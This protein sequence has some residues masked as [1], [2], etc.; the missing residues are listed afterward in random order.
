MDLGQ[1]VSG[2]GRVSV[3]M[4]NA[5]EAARQARQSQL[6]TEQLNRL[7]QLRQE[8]LNAPM[9]EQMQVPQYGPMGELPV[10]QA[11]LTLP[12][13]GGLRQPITGGT[14]LPPQASLA[15]NLPQGVSDGYPTGEPG[16]AATVKLTPDEIRQGA[17]R[18]ALVRPTAVVADVLQAP[19]AA[20]LNVLSSGAR[21]INYM[22]GTNLPT[23]S[24]SMTPYT[25]KIRRSEQEL[26][27]GERP[28]PEPTAKPLPA[29]AT[30][31]ND[32]IPQVLP[33]ATPATGAA[34]AMGAIP[35]DA[36]ANAVEYVESGGRADAVSP[37][38]AR[39]PMQTMPGTLKDP[40]FGVTPAK[41]NSPEEMR[42]VGRDYLAA[43]QRKYGDNDYALIAYNW[44]PGN[45]DKWIK[46]GADPN[47]LPKET[48]EYVPKVKAALGIGDQP[49]VAAIPAPVRTQ[50]DFYLAN[51]QSIPMDMQRAM[52][53][54]QEIARLATMYQRAGM[55]M[56]FMEARAKIMELDNG[57][58]Y[59]QGMQGLQEF[60][61][62]NDPRRL[63]AVWSQYAGVPVGIQPR[64]DG[65]F[66]IV[67]NGRKTKEGISASDISDAAR[68]AFDQT[69]RQQKSAA[70]SEYSKEQ[71]KSQL[72]IQ[73]NNAQQLAQMIREVSVQRAQ[74]NT[75]MALEQLK[76]LRYDVKPTGAGDGTVI[77]TPPGSGIPFLFNPSGRT[78]EV[79]GKKITSNSA[80]PIAG[81]P[82]YGGAQTR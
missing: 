70:S 71:F 64:T 48:Q 36:L 9:P 23:P 1:L 10:A 8:M 7:D 15:V 24:F 12:M 19:A 33:A 55:G 69:Y 47:K 80:Y 2:A 35:F 66:D 13:G 79:D 28:A 25:D 82:S 17:N 22:F 16:S 43:M 74:G 52:Q 61:L 56:Q 51:P 60:T 62:A 45:T 73:E 31:A 68:S 81:L 30:P 14:R 72:K 78:I 6:Q 34:P 53:Q 11:G 46:A 44:G 4:R 42:R 5:E 65:K 27:A 57:M 39:G 63:Q 40:G 77:I 59:L 58:T 37:K 67:V 41:N 50:S 29:G 26:Q 75:S 38:G 3:G 21:G 20:G 76:Q 32:Q 49:S 18:L 54:R